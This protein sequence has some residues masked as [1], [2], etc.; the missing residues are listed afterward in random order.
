MGPGYF[1]KT[2]FVWPPDPRAPVG[3]PGDATYVA[4]DW[5]VRY[6]LNRNGNAFNNQADNDNTVAGTQTVNI[7]LMNNGTGGVLN[8]SSGN[9]QGNYPAVLRW[10]KSGPMV[11]PPNLRSGR[12]LY[13]SS[14]P[15]DVTVTGSDSADVQAD[16]VFWKAYI[17]Y[18]LSTGSLAGTEP[19]GWPEGV[20]PA[21]DQNATTAYHVDGGGALAADPKPYM[22]YADN[23]SRPRLH[24]WFG[25]LTM[26]TFLHDYNMWSGT[27]HQ[28]Q[29]W[30]L[31][32]GVNSALDDIRNNHPNDCCGLAYFSN[33]DYN[34]IIVPMGTDWPTLKNALFFPRT[35]LSSIPTTPTAEWRPYN[36]ANGLQST[37]GNIPNAQGSTDPCTGLSLAYNLLSSSPSVNSDPTRRGRRGAMKMVIFETDGIPN[38]T[39]PFNLT[40]KGYDSYYTF[41]GNTPDTDP[42]NAAYDVVTQIAKPMAPTNGTG[43]DSGLSLPN[44]PARVYAIGFGDIFSTSAGPTAANFLLNVQKKGNTSASTDT[45]IPSTQ[46]ITGSYQTR[47]ANL[48]SALERICDSGVQ[49]TLIE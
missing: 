8:G 49:V 29:S 31:K 10:V 13:Y 24:F 25:P 9:W 23:P 12:V 34:S 45:S 18:V 3:N 6:F 37:R 1:G 36:A 2:F 20:T 26:M 7:E 14:I 43:V 27:T 11:L 44:A 17:D 21:I 38:S 47:I 48:R 19:V 39:Q 32:A 22:N 35:L 33:N 28:A 5:R 40:K 41:G 42:Y 4:G 46:I 16:K 15:N 30:Q